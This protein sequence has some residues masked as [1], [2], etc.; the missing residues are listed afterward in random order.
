MRGD[1]VAK[2]PKEDSAQ[3]ACSMIV[4]VHKRMKKFILVAQDRRR[5]R[6]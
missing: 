6:A 3:H 2:L 5:D 4:V 1:G